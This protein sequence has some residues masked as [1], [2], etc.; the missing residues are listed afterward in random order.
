MS[1]LSLPR[2]GGVMIGT[3]ER[4]LPGGSKNVYVQ[5]FDLQ[6]HFRLI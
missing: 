6:M 5:I 4:I 3:G 1:N 2:G